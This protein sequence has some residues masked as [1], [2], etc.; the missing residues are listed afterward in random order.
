LIADNIYRITGI[1]PIVWTIGRPID[2]WSWI[3]KFMDK[4]DGLTSISLTSAGVG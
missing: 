1:Q 2:G 3:I 4:I